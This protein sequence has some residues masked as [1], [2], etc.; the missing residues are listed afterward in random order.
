MDI[1]KCLDLVD[2]LWDRDVGGAPP[3]IVELAVSGSECP[4]GR[5][6]AEDVYALEGALTEELTTRRGAAARWGTGTLQERMS[7]GGE[8]PEPWAGLA[9][10][11]VELRAWKNAR[12][13]WLIITVADTDPESEVRLL[14][15]VSDVVPD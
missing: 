3:G 11:T 4:G 12:G 2:E 9:L 1:A 13:R 14:L 8:I 5:L 15:A 10:Q 6:T 7:R